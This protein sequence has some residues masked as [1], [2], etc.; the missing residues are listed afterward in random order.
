[1]YIVSTVSVLLV[2]V[3]FIVTLFVTHCE[4]HDYCCVFQSLDCISD[5]PVL[6]N[7]N[8]RDQFAA[9]NAAGCRLDEVLYNLENGVEIAL[10]R[11]QLWSKFA[12]D[13]VIFVDKRTSICE[14][15]FTTTMYFFYC[16]SSDR[17]VYAVVVRPSV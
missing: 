15:S 8:L 14:F 12:K 13:L 11:A 3:D 1:M 6:V 4:W 16:T 5:Q 9:A 2:I 10:H 7:C 17:I